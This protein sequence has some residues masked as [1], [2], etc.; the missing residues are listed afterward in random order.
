MLRNL[1]YSLSVIALLLLGSCR[2]DEPFKWNNRE[3][4]DGEFVISFIQSDFTT[5]SGT[6]ADEGD[7]N[8]VTLLMFAGDSDE[9]AL[10]GYHDFGSSFGTK[11]S[12]GT[13]SIVTPTAGLKIGHWILVA[14]ISYDDIVSNLKEQ[15]LIAD[16]A[17]GFTLGDF[18]ELEFEIP[19]AKAS[20]KSK[21]LRS[22]P[23][24]VNNL[25][26]ASEGNVPVFSL[27]SIYSKVSV[28]VENNDNPDF[29]I[30]GVGFY[31]QPAML[32]M[33][34][35]P[36]TQVTYF[37]PTGDE[38]RLISGASA[39]FKG[40]YSGTQYLQPGNTV[41]FFCAPMAAGKDEKGLN[42]L[43]DADSN[44]NKGL[45]LDAPYL[46][47]RGFQGVKDSETQKFI[48]DVSK[49]KQVY[50]AARV[51]EIPANANLRA[52]I[53]G[54]AGIGHED[55]HDAVKNPVG[56]SIRFDVNA[57]DNL[58]SIVSD[59]ENAIATPDKVEIPTS[60]SAGSTSGVGT[61]FLKV[62]LRSKMEKNELKNNL[63]IIHKTN[64]LGDSEY[65]WYDGGSQMAQ[66]LG[67]WLDIKGADIDKLESNGQNE[68]GT[69]FFNYMIKVP[70][71]AGANTGSVRSENIRL[72]LYTDKD[73]G[74]YLEREVYI[75][76]NKNE[77][78]TADK[79]FTVSAKLGSTDISDYLA[80][81]GAD[82][83]RAGN[84]TATGCYG[85]LPTENN[86]RVRNNGLH[87]PYHY[88][89][90]STYTYTVKP[91]ADIPDGFWTLQISPDVKDVVTFDG[92]ASGGSL[93]TSTEWKFTFTEKENAAYT[94][95][96]EA[97]KLI[98]T[99]EGT[100][101]EYSLDI[102]QTGFFHNNHY[103]EVF[104]EGLTGRYWLDRNWGAK[105]AGMAVAANGTYLEDSKWPLNNGTAP[106]GEYYKYNATQLPD[107]NYWRVPTF[108]EMN[109]LANSSGFAI[110]HTRTFDTKVPY[111]SP[112]YTFTGQ[113]L[114][115][116]T[117]SEQSIRSYL[118]MVM[119]NTEKNLT[120]N[121]GNGYYLTS[122][123]DG[124]NGEYHYYQVMQ[125]DGSNTTSVS[126]EL[127]KSEA[128]LQLRPCSGASLA[129]EGATYVLNVKGYTH[130][131]V[132]GVMNMSGHRTVLTTWPGEQI[133]VCSS[134]GDGGTIGR[135]NTLTLNT[136]VA[137][138]EL[139]I[140]C[141]TI[142]PDG[143]R[144]A[145]K[146]SVSEADVARR[147][148][149]L[150]VFTDEL[151]G[152]IE[153]PARI[154]SLN[155][156]PS[157]RKALGLDQTAQ[158]RQQALAGHGGV[159][160]SPA[161]KKAAP[162]KT[163]GATRSEAVRKVAYFRNYVTGETGHKDDYKAG[164]FEDFKAPEPEYV[165]KLEGE[166]IGQLDVYELGHLGDEF[167]GDIEIEPG[168]FKIGKY[169]KV[170]NTVTFVTYLYADGSS[171]SYG[172]KAVTFTA[173]EAT[174]G[175]EWSSTVEGM[176]SVNFF[177]TTGD[178][179]ISAYKKPHY[180]LTGPA[181]TLEKDKFVEMTS[182]DGGLTWTYTGYLHSAESYTGFEAGEFYISRY[183]PGPEGTYADGFERVAIKAKSGTS[184]EIK[185]NGTY[186]GENTTLDNAAENWVS[187]VDAENV[188]F[189]YNHVT[190]QLQIAGIPMQD[191]YDYYLDG[192]VTA[193]AWGQTNAKL[194]KQA[195]GSFVW[196]GQTNTGTG[197]NK[198][199]F[200][201]ARYDKNTTNN[202]KWMYCT[203]TNK[204]I[205][206]SFSVQTFNIAAENNDNGG[207]IT[208]YINGKARFTYTP[209]S[210]TTG[211]LKVEKIDESVY[212][213]KGPAINGWDNLIEMTDNHDGTYTWSGSIKTGEFGISK[214]DKDKD[215]GDSESIF[216]SS[217]DGKAVSDNGTYNAKQNGSN[218]NS[219]ISGEVTLTFTP[220]G[221]T[222]TLVVS[223]YVK[224]TPTEKYYIFAWK[225]DNYRDDFFFESPNKLFTAPGKHSQIPTDD[226]NWIWVE[227]SLF[228]NSTNSNPSEYEYKINNNNSNWIGN[229]R[230][231]SEMNA[232]S[233][234]SDL[235]T[236]VKTALTN[237]GITSG[238]IE[239]IYKEK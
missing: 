37:D 65:D 153:A 22:E 122:T 124:S 171:T 49:G 94:V 222:G 138:D 184:N 23:L 182:S 212:Y 46:I 157:M 210:E 68:A 27:R 190:K 112:T 21:I 108:A 80:F 86:E 56:L 100:K 127:N 113:T 47:V 161:A 239:K 69:D 144:M 31:K 30:T 194:T 18:Y 110:T 42:K 198:K 131:Y 200:G 119:I 89:G 151:T 169:K 73:A 186:Q 67:Q 99:K 90:S 133:A 33:E 7:V 176:V 197:D 96:P 129:S 204:D 219:T 206:D 50:F 105:A 16:N 162:R 228:D 36:L 236:A 70:L 120:G 229:N 180:H 205:F 167:S 55:I 8:T 130:V 225:Y 106:V 159:K 43:T 54:A 216:F 224:Q 146:S 40:N 3:I 71:Q 201:I 45:G 202:K 178:L 154:T 111:Y 218:W 208:N 185:G 44:S 121:S 63:K 118:P 52:F 166:A 192:T 5:L 81:V 116:G 38:S 235:P 93:S 114:D 123:E 101:T 85:T 41:E 237:D 220:N 28:S 135:Y 148:G 193:T 209:T 125:F 163:S 39:G 214:Y 64:G 32:K 24:E 78:N 57:D 83:K 238:M 170:G 103:Y 195:D 2:S 207:N 102:Y 29:L 82:G 88:T 75:Y 143:K 126:M 174:S 223:G 139:Y 72:R 183:Y 156:V 173:K 17:E 91:K 196:E 179:Q 191:K 19:S 109:S 230:K 25:Q 11:D 34:A 15:N 227:K 87:V 1:L 136:P 4:D 6:R 187:K 213:I 115:N 149:Q 215:N 117:K 60:G 155:Q 172:G 152:N 181:V 221:K 177:P 142:T 76:Q 137:Y 14:N 107:G 79:F 35:L 217:S 12:S 158:R 226:Y 9:S 84:G 140:I 232:S 92:S 164:K 168:N 51:S 53:T 150:V 128:L 98:V 97:I 231:I 26:P 62:Y 141:N 77:D 160:S 13:Y 175:T 66:G 189:T 48:F 59:G 10:L 203:D 234:Y 188:T 61:T 147:E 165:Y 58:V 132:Y 145:G 20:Y 95:Y 211:V 74:K 199:S 233:S 134:T 104:Q